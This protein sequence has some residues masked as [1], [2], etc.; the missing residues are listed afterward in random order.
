MFLLVPSHEF[1]HISKRRLEIIIFVVMHI[2]FLL[3]IPFARAI[4]CLY[5][6]PVFSVLPLSCTG[7]I[8][9]QLHEFHTFGLSWG[10]Y[11]TFT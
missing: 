10:R 7:D 5:V 2:S 1:N 6:Y 4:P 11:M 9:L 8:L 3:H